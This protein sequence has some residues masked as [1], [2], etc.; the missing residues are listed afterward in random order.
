M[1]AQTTLFL[2]A[3]S[4][5][6]R[7]RVLGVPAVTDTSLN[8]RARETTLFSPWFFVSASNQYDASHEVH[9]N[10]N[11]PVTVTLRAFGVAGVQLGV[12]HTFTLAANATVAKTALLDLMVAG[13]GTSGGTGLTHNGAFGAISAN[14]TTASG[15]TGLAFDSPF[16]TRNQGAT[17]RPIR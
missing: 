11:Q 10:T 12:T 7:I 8:L 14:T 6:Y 3:T 4:G 1:F 5:T 2:P 16:T 15:L 17:G 9:N 13:D